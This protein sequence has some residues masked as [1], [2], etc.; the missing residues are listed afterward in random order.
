MVGTKAY[1]KLNGGMILPIDL[2]SYNSGMYFVNVTIDGKT[3][4]LK[5][6]KE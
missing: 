5:L 3:A 6:I 1:G 2:T 4:V